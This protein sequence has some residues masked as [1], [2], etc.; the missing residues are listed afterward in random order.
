MNGT[1]CNVLFAM[2][3]YEDVENDT[4]IVFS[5]AELGWWVDGECGGGAC[6]EHANCTSLVSPMTKGVGFRC[7]CRDGYEGDGFGA[8][9]G[10]QGC[11]EG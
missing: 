10:G 4:M 11:A 7:K 9:A 8:A 1:G 2:A 5:V 3:T 6:S